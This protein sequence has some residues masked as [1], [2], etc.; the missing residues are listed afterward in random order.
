MK[1]MAC[2]SDTPWTLHGLPVEGPRNREVVQVLGTDP[3]NRGYYLLG[4]DRTIAYDKHSFVPLIDNSTR[5][6]FRKELS[7]EK[8][9]A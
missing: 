9:R 1:H 7:R 8:I 6:D 3:T 2:V 5:Y 4:Y